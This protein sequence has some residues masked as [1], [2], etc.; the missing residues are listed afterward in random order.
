MMKEAWKPLI[1]KGIDYSDRFYIS[2]HGNIYSTYCKHILKKLVNKKGYIQVSASYHGKRLLIKIHRAVAENF[3]GG[4]KKG[5][6]VNH[7]DGNKANNNYTNLEWVTSGDNTR[8]AHES[9]LCLFS[10]PIICLNTGD[11]FPSLAAAARWC[12]LDE[13]SSS[14]RRYLR[15]EYRFAG[16]DPVTKEPLRWRLL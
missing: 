2:N 12:G 5:F 4:Y 9:G 6:V 8:H 10:K 11:T 14:F 3:V 7:K 13:K 1:Y 16:R 15:G